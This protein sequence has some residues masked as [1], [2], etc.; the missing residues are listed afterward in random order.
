MKRFISALFLAAVYA[1]DEEEWDPVK[2]WFKSDQEP[3]MFDAITAGAGGSSLSLS[4]KYGWY[5]RAGID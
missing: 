2:G 5:T 3:V 1:E 4:G